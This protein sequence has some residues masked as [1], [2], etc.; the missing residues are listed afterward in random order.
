ML[1]VDKQSRRSFENWL[2]DYD[3]FKAVRDVLT[4]LVKLQ[5]VNIERKRY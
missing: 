2:K 4:T 5:I 3:K 1:V